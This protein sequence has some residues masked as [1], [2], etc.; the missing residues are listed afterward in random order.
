MIVVLSIDCVIDGGGIKGISELLILQH[1]MVAV[2]GQLGLAEEP[3]P[4]DYFDLVGGTSTG[5]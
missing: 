1:I 3:L 5:G 4:C 2:Q